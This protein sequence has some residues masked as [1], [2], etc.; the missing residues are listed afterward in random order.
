[1]TRENF[2]AGLAM[3]A[4]Y[5]ALFLWFFIKRFILPRPKQAGKDKKDQ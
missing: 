2:G 3:Y 1:V 4:S 5:F